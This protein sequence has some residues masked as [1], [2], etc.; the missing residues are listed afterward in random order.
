MSLLEA[1]LERIRCLLAA[2]PTVKQVVVFGSIDTGQ[3]HEWSDLD[4]TV[5]EE[6]NTPFIERGLPLVRLIMP[7]V[8]MQFL[9]YTPVEMHA[10]TQKPFIQVEVLGKGKVLPMQPHLDAQRWLTCTE[11]DLRMAEL[12]LSAEIFNQTCFHAQ[13]CG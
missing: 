5:I 6:S 3:A 12:A 7:Q 10:L 4:L 1:G 11:Q 2:P 9:V 8:G 13:Q